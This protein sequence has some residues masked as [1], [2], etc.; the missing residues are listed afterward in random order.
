MGEFN[1]CFT[2]E[3]LPFDGFS[4]ALQEC[5]HREW[6]LV[7]NTQLFD[8]WGPRGCIQVAGERSMIPVIGEE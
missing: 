3:F 1:S 7:A 8:C 5:P 6:A 4:L 2:C